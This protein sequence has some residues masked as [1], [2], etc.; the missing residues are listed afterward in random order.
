MW[1]T[2]LIALHAITG[3][4]ALLAGCVA[5]RRPVLFGTYLWSLVSTVALLAA[6]VAEE[7]GR[8]DG[9]VRALFAAF[10][11]LGLVMV[12]LAVDARR[13]PAGSAG[14]IDR[15]GFTLVSLLDAFVV[16]MVLN[17]GAPVVLVVA[18]GVIVAVAGHFGLRA[19]KAGRTATEE[20]VNP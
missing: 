9:A 4:M 8:I 16:I 13:L 3:T 18:A 20:L 7:W 12:W 19:A 11:V 15:V 17:L 6:A 14:Y 2:I 1:H 5:H 10:T